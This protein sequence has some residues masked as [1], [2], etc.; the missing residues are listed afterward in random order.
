MYMG[1]SSEFLTTVLVVV[2][3]LV[4][5]KSIFSQLVAV[6]DDK[7]SCLQISIIAK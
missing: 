4:M 1:R 5:V 3:F 7:F 2:N 6:G